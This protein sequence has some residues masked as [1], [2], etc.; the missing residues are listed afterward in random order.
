M[1]CDHLQHTD[2]RDEALGEPTA[3][4]APDKRTG[5]IF[6][7][8]VLQVKKRADERTRTADLLIT[9]VRSVVAEGCSGVQIPHR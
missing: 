1:P 7:L 8:R 3:A 2:A 6:F 9:S 4:K 5:G